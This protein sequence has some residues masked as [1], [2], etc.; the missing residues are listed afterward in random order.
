VKRQTLVIGLLVAS[1]AS[2]YG[3]IE[4]IATPCQQGICL[5]WWPRLPPL[6]GWHHERE[7]SL[8]YGSNALAPDGFTFASADV[9]IYAR[10]LYKPRVPETTSLEM[11]IAGDR[12]KFLA[13]DPTIVAS[14]VAALTT[15]D[16]QS[17]RSVTFFPKAKG[18]W[19]RVTYGEE[20]DF[21]LLFIISARSREA[22]GLKH[23]DY[24]SLIS[25]YRAKSEGDGTPR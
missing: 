23:A 13:E 2:A 17:L 25:R 6:A 22:Y 12:K 3:E 24:E 9:V 1:S 15:A 20:G 14:E 5:N 19:E 7:A 21:F 18:N 16:G 8:Q 11:L 10:A 4:K